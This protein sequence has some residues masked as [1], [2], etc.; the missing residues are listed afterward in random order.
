MTAI[1]NIGT[2][3]MLQPPKRDD[4][5][6]FNQLIGQMKT[7]EEV[8]PFMCPKSNGNPQNCKNCVGF[9]TC[10]AGQRA[11]RLTDEA[12][13]AKYEQKWK[14]EEK[15]EMVTNP[16]KEREELRAACESGNAWNY[17]MET[18]GLTKDA[19]GELLSRLI[20]R[21]PG[22]A[23]DYGGSRRI[24]QRPKVVK[25]T[26]VSAQDAQEQASEPKEDKPE[27]PETGTPER[28]RKWLEAGQAAVR[29]RARK[30]CEEAMASGNP[31]QWLRDH[32]ISEHRVDTTLST[33]RKKYPELMKDEPK[34][35]G[36]MTARREHAMGFFEEV[37]AQEDPIAYYMEK[38]GVSRNAAK[39]WI[40]QAKK[41]YLGETK[42]TK[43]TS[44]EMKETNS[45]TKETEEDEISLADFLKGF[46]E[47]MEPEKDPTVEE[48]CV[49][50]GLKEESAENPAIQIL[51]KQIEEKQAVFQQYEKMIQEAEQAV[52][53]AQEKLDRHL[54]RKAQLTK[55]IDGIIRAL[56][57]LRGIG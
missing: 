16:G 27:G 56:D 35:M 42:V 13:R 39:S 2:S 46:D 31:A 17:L 26:P 47:A 44:Q 43:E 32:G 36:S 33:W 15:H 25:V 19:A 41:K 5:A 52:R 34:R 12:E 40:N 37:M 3:W 30:R 1:Q 51:Q 9:R 55:E 50:F 24:M 29:E 23:A 54:A 57:A 28:A 4:D 7:I 38:R 48:L 14:A 11:M 6:A 18:R 8:R 10:T 21:Y 53:E 45:E 22:I 20:K 49:P